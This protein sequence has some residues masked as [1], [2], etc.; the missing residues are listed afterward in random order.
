VPAYSRHCPSY[1]PPSYGQVIDHAG[2]LPRSL[3]VRQVPLPAQPVQPGPGSEAENIVERLPVGSLIAVLLSDDEIDPGSF[4]GELARADGFID[5]PRLVID[6]SAELPHPRP[7]RGVRPQCF[8]GVSRHSGDIA[9]DDLLAAIPVRCLMS[10]PE[11]PQP[12][13]P[14]RSH[15]RF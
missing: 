5:R 14:A 3:Q 10:G 13:C 12:R 7:H 6:G 11:T 15:A 9:E 2:Q 4:C 1:S 8:D